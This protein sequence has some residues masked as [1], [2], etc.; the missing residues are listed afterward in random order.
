MKTGV[1]ASAL[2]PGLSVP[3]WVPESV[4]HSARAKYTRDVHWAYAEAIKAFGDAEDD[5]A[6][7]ALAAQ[8]QVRDAYAEIVHEDLAEIV[9]HYRPLVSDP[10][11][12]AVWRELSRQRNGAFLHPARAPSA[13]DAGERQDAAI[14]EVFN[15]AIECQ[16]KRAATT[17][18]GKAEQQRRRY[19]AQ[20]EQLKRDAH[21]MMSQPLLFCGKNILRDNRR[22]EFRWKL[23]AAADAYQEYARA[24]TTAQPSMPERE[25]DGRARWVAQTIGSKFRDLFGSPMYGL[26]A[27][28]TSVVL[29]RQI[30]SSRARQWCAPHY[31]ADKSQKIVL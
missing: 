23:N 4:A 1:S 12:R 6:C 14:V 10:R 20:A 15:T 21:T 2:A 7:D 11:M 8:D 24:I 5:A 31:P 19:L 27:T 28:I 17:T 18:R 22:S 26:T 9:D 29:G 16:E 13:A 25:H 3:P 30:D